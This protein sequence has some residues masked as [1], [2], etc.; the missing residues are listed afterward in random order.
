MLSVPSVIGKTLHLTDRG[1]IAA[2]LGQR[3]EDML[4]FIGEQFAAAKF[5]PAVGQVFG[6][7]VGIVFFFLL[8]S[9]AHT[10]IVAMIALLYMMARA[11]D[12][13]RQLKRRN[14]HGVPT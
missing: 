4:R 10:P 9:A 14:R 6:W 5:S 3:S 13:P 12:M 7:I 2:V 11:R 1:Q 8:L